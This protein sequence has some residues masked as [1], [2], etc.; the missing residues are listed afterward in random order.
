MASEGQIPEAGS[1]R[2]RRD[3]IIDCATRLFAERGYEGASMADLAEAVGMRKASL[4]YHFASKDELYAAVMERLIAPFGAAMS[5]AAQTTGSFR[6][7]L[8]ALSVTVQTELGKSRFAARLLTREVMNWGPFVRDRLAEPILAALAAAE[9][10]IRAGQKAGEFADGD[11]K[12]VV[13]STL[14]LHFYPY[15]IV[16]ISER[17]AGAA[18]HEGAF[19]EARKEAVRR[20]I[21][22]F[23][24]TGVASGVVPSVGVYRADA[25]S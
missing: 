16:E 18:I 21:D 15:A 1:A 14:A 17:F 23:V 25:A 5:A 4:F 2:P 3:E 20:H 7:R 12:Q 24:C 10:F 6:E 22:A 13:L 11:P 19:T 9:A 8:E